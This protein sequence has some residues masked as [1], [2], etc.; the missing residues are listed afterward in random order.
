MRVL[1]WQPVAL[2]LLALSGA[3]AAPV[4]VGN[5]A[6]SAGAAT[7][8]F[9]AIPNL[10]PVGSTYP[11]VN[12]GG[13]YGDFWDGVND[14]PFA[15]PGL[16][17]VSNFLP[18]IAVE[19][20]QP[21]C[22]FDVWVEF[23]MQI[24][25]AGFQLATGMLNPGVRVEVYQDQT[26]LGMLAFAATPQVERFVGVEDSGGFNRI[27]IYSPSTPNGS[28]AFSM[29]DLVYDGVAVPEPSLTQLSLAGLLLLAGARGLGRWRRRSR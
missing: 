13:V 29:D 17:V 8:T 2:L 14:A 16:Q 9:D 28:R 20:G 12:I 4:E 27:R 26:L 10:S 1:I 22:C 24:T 18:A 15:N 21:T 5:G 23:S 25:R 19:P 3:V 11:G 7:I 6:F